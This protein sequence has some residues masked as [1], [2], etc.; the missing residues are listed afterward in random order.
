[1]GRRAGGVCALLTR[2]DLAQQLAAHSE[3]LARQL[4]EVQS[5]KL[6]RCQHT[7]DFK[8]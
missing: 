8:E 1:M 4:A 5:Y 7:D 2:A 6:E 3:G